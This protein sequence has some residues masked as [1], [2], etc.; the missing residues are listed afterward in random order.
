MTSPAA[1]WPSLQVRPARVANPTP[2]PTRQGLTPTHLRPRAPGPPRPR[3]RGHRRARLYGGR[4]ASV[5]LTHLVMFNPLAGDAAAS[6]ALP[7]LSSDPTKVEFEIGSAETPGGGRALI[8]LADGALVRLTLP[9]LPELDLSAARVASEVFEER[10]DGTGGKGWSKP[11]LFFS[12]NSGATNGRRCAQSWS[13][14]Q[15]LSR[16]SRAAACSSSSSTRRAPPSPRPSSLDAGCPPVRVPP[17]APRPH[18][19][20]VGSPYLSCPTR[21]QEE[22]PNTSPMTPPPPPRLSMRSSPAP[23]SSSWNGTAAG[24]GSPSPSAAPAS[25]C[26]RRAPRR[27]RRC[28]AG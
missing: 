28:G 25:C 24:P 11:R 20:P 19:H 4:S 21:P 17:S 1:A 16:R 27:S 8:S 14:G 3:G 13:A 5:S 6:I 9:E 22:S 7:A 10:T 2:G 15:G 26:G 12:M 23:T 18:L